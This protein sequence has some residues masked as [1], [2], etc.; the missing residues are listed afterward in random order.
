MCVCMMNELFVIM[1][2]AMILSLSLSLSLALSLAL[3][4]SHT[5]T[6]IFTHTPSAEEQRGR[7]FK[8]H[9]QH[10]FDAIGDR[11]RRSSLLSDRYQTYKLIMSYKFNLITY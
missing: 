3:S 8:E 1:V 5:H 7:N 2:I 10:S 6:S 9:C 4:L 11:V